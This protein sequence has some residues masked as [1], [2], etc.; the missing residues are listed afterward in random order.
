M[1]IDDR[2]RSI[3]KRQNILAAIVV[4][5]VCYLACRDIR[6]E[7]VG[8]WIPA[9]ADA[10]GW[11][12]AD[13]ALSAEI[14][15][16]FQRFL[17]IPPWGNEQWL[18][19]LNYGVNT[20]A[21]HART[22]HLGIPV[23]NGWMV[24][25]DLRR[26]APDSVRLA[27]LL[28]TWDGLAVDDPYF[29]VPATN[30]NLKIAVIA[31][32]LDQGQAVTLA[33]LSLSVGSVYRA[34]WFLT[35]ALSQINGGRYYDFRQVTRKPEQGS[36]L[37]AWLSARGLFV[38]STQ[39]AGGERRA[40]MFRSQVTGKPR[41]V[42][43]FPTL[44]GGMGSITRDL[45]DGNVE[46]GSHPL[47]N[48]LKFSD[49]GSEVI[50][51][52]PNGLL[53]YVLADSEG[54]IVDVAPPDLVRDHTVPPPHTARLQ[55]ARSCISCHSLAGEDGWRKVTNDVQRLLNSQLNVFADF[56]AEFT[57]EQV[58]D[59]L[60]GL[61]ALDV[62]HADGLLSRARRDHST[63]VF[64]CAA[65]IQFPADRSIVASVGQLVTSIVNSYDYDVIHPRKAALELGMFVP[66]NVAD[67]ISA[68]LGPP[69]SVTEV[70]PIV[71]FLRIGVPVNRHDFEIVYGDMAAVTAANRKH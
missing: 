52:Q 44:S 61:Y 63:A 6:A 42:D 53:D 24:R 40:A 48:L 68:V 69:N 30:T 32:H 71:G 12:L 41:R 50:V 28:A 56:G 60:A 27:T 22:I 25:Y 58:V 21:S 26:L 14:D 47:R 10:V 65:G 57:R 15:R 36:A 29:H 2:L 1:S 33:N 20:A 55:P 3:E 37:D 51:A 8:R 59:T 38:G 5:L 64:R 39:T 31:P 7:D 43:L 19:A 54:N 16:P 45:K 23:A 13:V 34:D 4:A 35:K 17:W 70:D 46:A 66:A 62:E 9:P 49:D 18:A 67:P 11:A